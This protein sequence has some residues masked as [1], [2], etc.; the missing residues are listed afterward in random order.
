M[1]Y[2]DLVGISYYPFFGNMSDQVDTVFSWLTA[3]FDGY[4]KPYAVAETGEAAE[5]LTLNVDGK[6]WQIDGS[7]ER[8]GC[9]LSKAV[10]ACPEQAFRFHNL[11]PL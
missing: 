6:P 9:V 1:P 5:K 8:A 2:N 4:G 3:Q 10:C 11:L 7:S